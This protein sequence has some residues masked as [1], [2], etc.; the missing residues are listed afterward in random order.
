MHL[1]P[2]PANAITDVPGLTV[3]HAHDVAART[4]VTVLLHPSCVAA[5][6]DARGGAP[7][8]RETDALAPENLV[9]RA[10]AIVFSGGSV[11]GFAAADAVVLA[12]SARGIGLTL[13]GDGPKL[14]L[15]PA[16]VL[17]DIGNGGDK[18][19]G[20]APPYA[21]L[22]ALALAAAGAPCEPGRHGA[23]HGARAGLE[24]GGLGTASLDLGDGLVVGALAAVNAVGTARLSD[25]SFLAWPWELAGEF[26]GA[27]PGPAAR[28]PDPLADTRLAR[29]GRLH[30]G[31]NTIL[32]AVATSARL[33]SA[34]CRRVAIMAHDGIARAVTP[35]HT[36]FDGDVVFAL[37]MGGAAPLPGR[38][39]AWLTARVGDAAA[40]CLARA[41]ARAVFA[42]A[43]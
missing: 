34:Q 15:V 37:S 38:S 40:S 29:L 36:P 4:G 2:G 32:A 18:A 13:A 42:S 28:A 14:P 31:A 41:I 6:V 43:A 35:A 33:T 23:G 16:A 26:G 9:G 1:K 25:G 3:G 19:W 5:G 39:P 20:D 7:G 8:T 10:D 24:P 27:R 12:L 30:P 21:A 11:F 22:G 17:H